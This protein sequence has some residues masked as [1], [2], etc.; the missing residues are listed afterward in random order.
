MTLST[1]DLVLTVPDSGEHIAHATFTI[2]RERAIWVQLDDL[3]LEKA[4][5]VDVTFGDCHQFLRR[6]W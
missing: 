3:T 6:A 4:E 5:L 1:A 2:D